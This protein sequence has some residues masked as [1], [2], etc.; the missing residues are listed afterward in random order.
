MV[1]LTSR[2]DSREI[3]Q[4]E[5]DI[6][7]DLPTTRSQSTRIRHVIEST[8]YVLAGISVDALVGAASIE[9]LNV[10]RDHKDCLFT[11]ESTSKQTAMLHRISLAQRARRCASKLIGESLSSPETSRLAIVKQ[12][13]HLKLT[14]F[15][16]SATVCEND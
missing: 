7:E 12:W 9:S 6:E 16:V 3:A 15:Q 13:K 4:D 1:P 2:N 5:S 11:K 14:T 10:F 8:F